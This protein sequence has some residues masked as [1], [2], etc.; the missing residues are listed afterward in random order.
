MTLPKF[1]FHPMEPEEMTSKLIARSDIH[2]YIYI[3]TY[4]YIK[5]PSIESSHCTV[6]TIPAAIT[7][8]P[9][10]ICTTEIR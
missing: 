3:Y 10:A 1:L 6:H 4:I 7:V 8:T 2:T 9:T 5:V